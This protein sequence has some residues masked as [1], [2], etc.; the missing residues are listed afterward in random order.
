MWIFLGSIYCNAWPLSSWRKVSFIAH[1]SYG[2]WCSYKLDPK[3]IETIGSTKNWPTIGKLLQY[4]LGKLETQ[5]ALLLLESVRLVGGLPQ[6][7]QATKILSV[8]FWVDSNVNS[9]FLDSY[10]V[11][12]RNTFIPGSWI[13]QMC[14]KNLPFHKK[15]NLPKGRTKYTYLEDPSMETISTNF[16]T[17]IYWRLE[18]S[19]E[20]SEDKL[21]SLFQ[22][23]LLQNA[24]QQKHQFDNLNSRC[25]KLK[26]KSLANEI[27][28]QSVFSTQVSRQNSLS[29][30]LRDLFPSI[31]S[32]D[33]FEAVTE[34]PMLRLF[35]VT[36]RTDSSYWKTSATTKIPSKCT[37]NGVV[38][39]LRTSKH[40]LDSV[41]KEI[42]FEPMSL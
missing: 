21:M 24:E 22:A 16:T 6:K 13:F 18:V 40:L 33:L 36:Q 32:I 31:S 11:H 42:L 25:E 12:L 30:H 26:D 1:R 7:L 4:H 35:K 34:M 39:V 8:S 29:R 2:S 3:E 28:Q 17:T 41:L 5:F 14:K 37:E 27:S 15:K 9:N 20:K 19:P 23:S 38:S 10:A